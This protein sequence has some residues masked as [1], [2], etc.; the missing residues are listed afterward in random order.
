MN[1]T[2]LQIVQKIVFYVRRFTRKW[3]NMGP[4]IPGLST[5]KTL[6][7]FKVGKWMKNTGW[8]YFN[9]LRGLAD[10]L[11]DIGI[12]RVAFATDNLSH[13]ET[14]ASVECEYF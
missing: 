4:L 11:T 5:K 7:S 12:C 14:I 8:R 3:A 2:G 13:F 6:K 10:R 9:C 1:I